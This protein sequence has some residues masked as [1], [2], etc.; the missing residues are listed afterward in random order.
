[1][2]QNQA[3]TKFHIDSSEN[4]IERQKH[5]ME[6]F[7]FLVSNDEWYSSLNEN[8]VW[9][10]PHHDRETAE[11][12]RLEIKEI[13]AMTRY[14]DA[15]SLRLLTEAWELNM[16]M[17][18]ALRSAQSTLDE[19]QVDNH[20]IAELLEEANLKFGPDSQSGQ[21]IAASIAGL[22]ASFNFNAEGAGLDSCVVCEIDAAADG[23][24]E[25]S[26]IV[27]SAGGETEELPGYEERPPVYEHVYE[28]QAIS[29]SCTV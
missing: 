19:H 10:N 7:K 28:E 4:M 21:N 5:A 17:I 8:D 18:Q 22:E 29:V 20:D 14:M 1:M 2:V 27:E 25:I 26:G 6:F 24:H 3:L 16:A 13:E 9:E 23:E 12:I 15:Q 11:M